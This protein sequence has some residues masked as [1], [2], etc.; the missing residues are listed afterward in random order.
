MRIL[1]ITNNMPPIVDGVGDYTFNLA[2]EFAY[3]G[4]KVSVICHKNTKI[5]NDYKNIQLFSIV[6]KWNKNAVFPILNIIKQNNID[7]VLLQYVPHGFHKKGLPFGLIRIVKNIKLTGVKLF[8]FCHEVCI[9]NVNGSFKDT[10]LRMIMWQ[11]TRK[12]ILQSDFIATSI[13]YYRTMIEKMLLKWKNIEI[14]PIASNIPQVTISKDEL[15]KLRKQVANGC[16]Y[17]VVF[18]GNRD[19]TTSLEALQILINK[20]NIRIR[21]LLIGNVKSEYKS[22]K[23]EIFRTGILEISDIGKFLAISSVL[24]LPAS[25][26]FGCSFKSGSLMA[27][28]Q[29]GVPVITG[30]GIFTDNSLCDGSNIIFADFTN[31]YD[32]AR[33]ISNLLGDTVLRKKLSDNAISLVK[34]V[35]WQSTYLKYMKIINTNTYECR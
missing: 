28:L 3:H 30:K 24:I 20:R 6:E 19:I 12:I 17:V 35:S 34:N 10:V 16:D 1:F 27:A 4:H 2:C 31:K 21:I 18:L 9:F 22:S 5:K 29:S 25:N 13:A 26:Q 11:I 33:C 32:I 7:I 15:I 8:T 14:I 23:L